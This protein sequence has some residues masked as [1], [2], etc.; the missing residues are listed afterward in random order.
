MRCFSCGTANPAKPDCLCSVWKWGQVRWKVS[1][2]VVAVTSRPPHSA[3]EN[4]GAQFVRVLSQPPSYLWLMLIPVLRC[5][6]CMSRWVWLWL[7]ADEESGFFFF[8]GLSCSLLQKKRVKLFIITKTEPELELWKVLVSLQ[9]GGWVCISKGVKSTCALVCWG[10]CFCLIEQHSS[11]LTSPPLCD[12]F[13]F[14]T[15]IYMLL[16]LFA[17]L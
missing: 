14:N 5:S 7:I 2:V 13:W 4:L 3:W 9:C 17:K 8:F 6:P 1:C 11:R 10:L 16:L 15:H 12:I